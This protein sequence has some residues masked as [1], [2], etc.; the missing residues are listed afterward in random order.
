MKTILV[1]TDFS[2]YSLPALQYAIH[3]ARKSGAKV[4]LLHAYDLMDTMKGSLK[5]FMDEQYKVVKEELL[6]KLNRIR[7]QVL[8]DEKLEIS[9]MLTYG[10]VTN[11]ILLVAE[12]FKVDFIVM[13]AIG[14]TGLKTT[15]L[16]SKTTFVLRNSKFPLLIIPKNYEWVKPRNVLITVKE[17]QEKVEIMKPVIELVELFQSTVGVLTFT[18]NHEEAYEVMADTRTIHLFKDRLEKTYPNIAISSVHLSGE[19]FTKTLEEYISEHKVDLLVMINHHNSWVHQ[20]IGTSI[21]QTMALHSEI[22][23]LSINP[24]IDSTF[25]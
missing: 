13:G 6:Q 22:P 2:A 17:E 1:P 18:D 3:L 7:D 8:Q 12:K 20:L 15:I 24:A 4:I 21:T 19:R 9:T 25:H 5:H 10:S 11:N 23:L 16:G 14:S